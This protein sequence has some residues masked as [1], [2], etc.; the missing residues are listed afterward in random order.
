M[1]EETG[2]GLRSR[3]ADGRQ[4]GARHR[5]A[6]GSPVAASIHGQADWWYMYGLWFVKVCGT[7]M[8]VAVRY[9]VSF[10]LILYQWLL[11]GT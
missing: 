7:F 10:V 3:A 11:L 6:M 2:A 9:F 1:G 4:S 8:L 5:G